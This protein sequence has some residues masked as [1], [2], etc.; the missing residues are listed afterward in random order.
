MPKAN[1]NK[2]GKNGWSQIKI[3]IYGFRA[4]SSHSNFHDF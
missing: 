2:F 3:K 1:E 4:L